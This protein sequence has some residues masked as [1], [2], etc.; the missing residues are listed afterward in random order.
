MHPHYTPPSR[1]LHELQQPQKLIDNIFYD[2][3]KK[4]FTGNILSSISDHL[5]QYLLISNQTELSLNNNEKE[6]L[7]I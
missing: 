3:T 4:N 1:L 6:T 7:K 2:F 5:T